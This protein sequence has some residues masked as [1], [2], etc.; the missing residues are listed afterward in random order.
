MDEKKLHILKIAGL[1]VF[2]LVCIFSIIYVITT[3]SN[4][5][6]TV[7]QEPEATVVSEFESA[8]PVAGARAV[9][10]EMPSFSLS[11]DGVGREI[12]ADEEFTVADAESM[13]VEGAP[14]ESSPAAA[15]DEYLLDVD[16]KGRIL[17]DDFE[18]EAIKN[19][20]NSRANVYARAPSR[21]MISKRS[22]ERNGN[23]SS[24]LLIKY[25]KQNTGGPNG[26]GG[27]CGYYTIIKN[28]KTGEYLDG[29]DYKNIAFWVRGESGDESFK[30]GLADQHWDK[31]GD[32]LKSEP[33]TAYLPAGRITT[34]W[35]K[36]EIPINTFFLD[37]ATLASITINFEAECFPEGSGSGVILI[38]DL[39]LEK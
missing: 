5:D 14:A 4:R 18:G 37:H 34:Q 27:W 31:I 28:Q 20:L 29:S 7:S 9:K 12:G 17:I 30:I 15:S 35:Q 33:V 6:Q 25:D 39:A 13:P 8:S 10:K 24:A 3:A 21:I 16:A 38:D 1:V 36:A 32:S 11:G 19:R 22:V 23:T 26:M 2:N